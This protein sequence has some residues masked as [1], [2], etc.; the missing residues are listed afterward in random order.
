MYRAKFREQLLKFVQLYD[1]HDAA[2]A[3]EDR[4]F[5]LRRR[6]VE[7]LMRPAAVSPTQGSGSAVATAGTASSAMT[8]G[9]STRGTSGI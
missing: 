1:E 6:T 8:A 7:E 4:R 5:A 2:R 3:V 9:R